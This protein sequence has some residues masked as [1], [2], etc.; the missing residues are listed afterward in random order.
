MIWC[1]V[2]GKN[3]VLLGTLL[4]A[5]V[6]QRGQDTGVQISQD[7]LAKMWDVATRT[8]QNWLALSSVNC[9]PNYAEVP[10]S[11]QI[12][13][14]E[15]AFLSRDGQ[16]YKWQISNTYK[17]SQMARVHQHIGQGRKI[18]RAAYKVMADRGVSPAKK[19]EGGERT[20]Q[21]HHPN[22]V[23]LSETNSAHINT[24]TYELTI[25]VRMETTEARTE[26]KEQMKTLYEPVPP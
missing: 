6:R 21:G 13:R 18:R 25:A 5:W 9:E 15:H 3:A 14:P 1:D 20:P 23:A 17:A 24:N 8:I 2:R 11:S 4:D 10:V 12:E 16:H 19:V 7:A 22:A 26:P